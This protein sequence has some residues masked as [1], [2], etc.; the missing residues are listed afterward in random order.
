MKLGKTNPEL[1]EASS[2]YKKIYN[3]GFEEGKQK[4]QITFGFID[5]DTIVVAW[6]IGDIKERGTAIGIEVSTTEAR[7]ILDDILR[8][9]DA[10]EGI[11]WN[12][13]DMAIQDYRS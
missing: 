5:K 12:V 8:N 11:N 1:L 2:L 6:D 13:V 9:H 4:K 10:N 3:K 7:E